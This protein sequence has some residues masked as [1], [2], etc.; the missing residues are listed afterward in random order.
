MIKSEEN[1]KPPFSTAL[2]SSSMSIFV[3]FLPSIS[4][5][6]QAFCKGNT[7]PSPSPSFRRTII[8]LTTDCQLHLKQS[9]IFFFYFFIQCLIIF[10]SLP[11][12]LSDCPSPFSIHLTSCSFLLLNKMRIRTKPKWGPFCVHQPPLSTGPALHCSCHA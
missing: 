7:S 6:N 2:L 1:L 4:L 8:N 10:S 12:L 3:S 5:L 11:Q 9:F